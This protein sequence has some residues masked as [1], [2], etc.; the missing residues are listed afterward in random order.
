M[1]RV[2][3]AALTGAALAWVILLL[4]APLAPRESVLVYALAG[5]VCH[6]RADR[7]FHLAGAP[8]PVCAR[9]FALYAS[10]AAA[11]AIAWLL[12]RWNATAPGA[13]AARLLFAAAAAPTVVTVALERLGLA[14]PSNLARAL[15]ALPLGAVAGWLFVRALLAEARGEPVRYHA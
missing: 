15:S 6:Q 2:L 13:R 10:G 14:A 1:P 7:S 4:A 12:G 8:L 3:A 5:E 9:C 11:A